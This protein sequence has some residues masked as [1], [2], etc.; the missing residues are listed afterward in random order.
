MTDFEKT[1]LQAAESEMCNA[2]AAIF[3]MLR[4]F[5]R[6]D[7]EKTGEVRASRPHADI[8]GRQ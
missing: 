3:A 2:N 7:N 4:H 5:D 8:Q 6:I 1:Q